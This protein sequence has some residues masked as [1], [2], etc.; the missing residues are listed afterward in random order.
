LLAALA[1][2]SVPGIAAAQGRLEAQYIATLAGI[3]IGK[4]NWT[5]DVGESHYSAAASG[6]TT[7]L[8]RL[9]TGGRATG[10][11]QGSLSASRPLA[12]SYAAT[13]VTKHRTDEIR[14]TVAG[15]DVKEARVDP[16]ETPDP[17][18]IP[19]TDEQRRGVVDPMTASLVLVP[20]G[21]ELQS[22]Q[23]CERRLAVFD[24]KLR[25]NL[26]FAFKRMEKVAAKNGYAGA[27]VVCSVAF[28]PV[29]GF[30]PDRSAIAYLAKPHGMEVWLVPIPGTRVLVPF[31]GQI[32]TP[33]GLGV[34]EATQ[35]VAQAGST[36]AAKGTKGAKTQ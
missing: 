11:A 35:F 33:V 5:V 3:P 25:Y 15:G 34:V 32:E 29:S 2:C 1:C 16:P 4:G 17:N 6:M 8:V 21:V 36:H 26:T 13:I 9:F 28:E 22:P 7:G 14:L 19:V 30:V 12:S 23:A 20:P 24:G 18:R 31:R 10:A 27:A